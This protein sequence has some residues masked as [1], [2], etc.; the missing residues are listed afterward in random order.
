MAEAQVHVLH[1]LDGFAE[2]ALPRDFDAT[3][4]LVVR[5]QA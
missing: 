5:T 3:E 1:M 4:P 2:P